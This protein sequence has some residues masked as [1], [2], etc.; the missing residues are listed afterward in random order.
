MQTSFF[1]LI[2]AALN[3]YALYWTRLNNFNLL[4]IVFDVTVE[5]VSELDTIK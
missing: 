5:A 4:S 1:P 2:D 3:G